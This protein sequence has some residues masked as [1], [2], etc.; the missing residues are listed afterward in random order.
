M[1]FIRQTVRVS[2][3]RIGCTDSL[4]LR[5]HQLNK[6]FYRAS[7]IFCNQHCYVIGRINQ[8]N[9][10][11]LIHGHCVSCLQSTE[12]C[13]GFRNIHGISSCQHLIRSAIPNCYQCCHYFC[14]TGRIKLFMCTFGIDYFVFIDV[15]KHSRCSNRQI[16]FYIF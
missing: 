3:M 1:L 8:E 16:S 5:I 2:K 15:H 12:R 13:T 4:S 14:Y 6:L 7:D 10:K 9:A 11:C